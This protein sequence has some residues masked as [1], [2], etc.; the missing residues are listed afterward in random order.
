MR[1]PILTPG[2]GCHSAIRWRHSHV[3]MRMHVGLRETRD[4]YVKAWQI[5][6]NGLKIAQSSSYI[7]P[8]RV[9]SRRQWCAWH[10]R[11]HT[12]THTYI[13]I[14]TNWNAEE[15][16]EIIVRN[17]LPYF[18]ASNRVICTQRVLGMTHKLNIFIREI[19][20]RHA[21]IQTVISSCICSAWCQTS[22]FLV[23][24]TASQSELM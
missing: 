18:T 14:Y 5:S 3:R 7:H 11:T 1:L 13:Y 12:H 17:A 15:Y 16:F 10:A 20:I 2:T 8:R 4:N 23:A 19:S 21:Y 24:N 22:L 6:L 9:S